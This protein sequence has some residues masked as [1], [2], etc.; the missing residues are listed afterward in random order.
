[1]VLIGCTGQPASEDPATDG[2]TRSQLEV[3]TDTAPGPADASRPVTT[4]RSSAAGI[5]DSAAISTLPAVCLD[6]SPIEPAQIGTVNTIV[7]PANTEAF[8]GS[9]RAVPDTACPGDVVSFVVSIVNTSDEAQ[10]FSPT[11]G[12]I[13]SSGGIAKWSLA[14]LSDLAVMMQ[15]GER[16][17]ATVTGTVPPVGPGIYRV[18]PEGARFFGEITVLDPASR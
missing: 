18:S 2:T 1:M 15:P 17:D 10:L 8:D 3:A 9:V 11:R 12:L 5:D 16:L 7:V 4:E 14:P 13:F 6:E